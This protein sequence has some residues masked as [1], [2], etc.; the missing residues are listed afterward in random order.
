[1]DILYCPI[2]YYVYYIILQ[3]FIL[4]YT[5]LNIISVFQHRSHVII[6]MIS[7]SALSPFCNAS[8]SPIV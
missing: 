5:I 4:N 7:N 3:Y 8:C 2:L 6:E 1:M